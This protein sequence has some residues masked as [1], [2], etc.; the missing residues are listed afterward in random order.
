VKKLPFI[1]FFI[2]CLQA[3]FLFGEIIT[4]SSEGDKHSPVVLT[5]VDKLLIAI[6]GKKVKLNAGKADQI[7]K[8]FSYFDSPGIEKFPI[9]LR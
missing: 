4:V 5:P 2:V 3:G 9:T 1:V 7:K 6:D 8:F